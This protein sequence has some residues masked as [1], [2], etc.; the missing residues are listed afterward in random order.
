M[1]GRP[2]YPP[3][4]TQT[5]SPD[6]SMEHPSCVRIHT[7]EGKKWERRARKV[8]LSFKSVFSQERPRPPASPMAR[9]LLRCFSDVLCISRPWPT[10]QV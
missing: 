5:G 8:R 1:E 6:S 7:F 10:P 9:V 4:A 2:R 3:N